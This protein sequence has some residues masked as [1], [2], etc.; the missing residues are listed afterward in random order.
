MSGIVR[1]I[2]GSKVGYKWV[3]MKLSV[4]VFAVESVANLCG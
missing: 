3:R 2:Y 1:K 4:S